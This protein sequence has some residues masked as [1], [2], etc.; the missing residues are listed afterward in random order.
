MRGLKKVDTKILLGM[1][2]YHNYIREHEAL[3]GKTTAEA[4]GIVIEG[5]NKWMTL[6]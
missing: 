4:R 6:I 2:I 3:K 5:G 1:Q